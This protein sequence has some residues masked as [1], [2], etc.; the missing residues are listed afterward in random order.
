VGLVLQGG[1]FFPAGPAAL[2]P[3]L[4]AWTRRLRVGK[5]KYET[6]RQKLESR[7]GI[8]RNWKDHD[9]YQKAFGGLMR[10]LKAGEEGRSVRRRE[11]PH[12]RSE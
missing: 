2:S 4:Y 8:F 11:I 12:I 10:D 6:R 7:K 1:I 3:A 5:R 9:E